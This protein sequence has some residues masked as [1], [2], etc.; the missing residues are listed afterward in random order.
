MLPTCHSFHPL[1][2]ARHPELGLSAHIVIYHPCH[3]LGAARHPELAWY[4]CAVWVRSSTWCPSRGTRSLT[5]MQD[6]VRCTWLDLG[7]S[8]WWLGVVEF[9]TQGG[10]I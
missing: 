9:E 8:G 2:A 5:N 4:G 10:H 1:G 3:P 7:G 6:L